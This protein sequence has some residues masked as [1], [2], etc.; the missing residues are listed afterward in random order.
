MA[1]KSMSMVYF[2]FS[3]VVCGPIA[4]I[5]GLLSAAWAIQGIGGCFF[6]LSYTCGQTEWMKTFIFGAIAYGAVTIIL[7]MWAKAK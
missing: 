7:K 4:L 2:V 3:L 6:S 1:N 5:T